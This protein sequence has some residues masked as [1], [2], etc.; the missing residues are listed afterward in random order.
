MAR[1][2]TADSVD[3]AILNVLMDDADATGTLIAERTGLSR[4]TIRT[5]LQRYAEERALLPFEQRISP[6][7]LGYP[8]R[9]F[10]TTTVV[11]R[12]LDAVATA[13]A[14]VPEVLEVSGVAG[15]ADLIVEIVARDSDDLYRIA[16]LILDIP[17]IVRTET[18]LVMRELVPYRI[19]QLVN[20]RGG[21]EA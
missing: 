21:M 1:S 10:V 2:Q 5:R 4:N 7:F 19:A 18:G 15:G 9:A 14:S 8:L 16:G 6:H 17:G 12:E 11:Q 13:L 20:R 3:R